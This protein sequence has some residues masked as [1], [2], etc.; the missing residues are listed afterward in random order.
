MRYCT[1]M[2]EM[3]TTSKTDINKSLLG[4][5]ANALVAFCIERD[6]SQNTEADY[7]EFLASTEK[8]SVKQRSILNSALE[9]VGNV[10]E[11]A[12]RKQICQV[13]MILAGLQRQ[14]ES[15]ELFE[16]ELSILIG[17]NEP[18]LFDKDAYLSDHN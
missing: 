8:M 10:G 14:V 2:S 12:Y 5:S 3:L 9:I 16:H 4:V 15:Q 11:E 17:P 7:N 6:T 18:T 1:C 13:T